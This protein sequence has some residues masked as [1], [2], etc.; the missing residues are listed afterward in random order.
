MNRNHIKT[1][2]GKDSGGVRNIR[3]RSSREDIDL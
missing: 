3:Y 1:S 2:N